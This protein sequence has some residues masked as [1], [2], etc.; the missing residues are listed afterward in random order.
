MRRHPHE[1]QAY[2]KRRSGFGT[3]SDGWLGR[4]LAT[5][6]LLAFVSLAAGCNGE[7]GSATVSFTWEAAPPVGQVFWVSYSVEERERAEVPGN[8]KASAVVGELTV[9][10]WPWMPERPITLAHG[11]NLRLIVELRRG[12]GAEQ[13]VIYYGVSEPFTLDPGEDIRVDVA[14]ELRR[15]TTDPPDESEAPPNDVTLEFENGATRPGLDDAMKASVILVAEVTALRAEIANDP[16]FATSREV[17]LADSCPVTVAGTYRCRVEGWDL[18]AGQTAE[19]GVYSVYARFFDAYGYPSAVRI[20][21]AAID[22]A[23]P[24]VLSA[25]VVPETVAPGGT[26]VVS[27]TTDE[28]IIEP[29]LTAIGTGASWMGEP[30][31]LVKEGKSW[32]WRI[33]VT[34]DAETSTVAQFELEYEDLVGNVAETTELRDLGDTDATS[35]L[36]DG[37]APKLSI[38]DFA[39]VGASARRLGPAGRWHLRGGDEV[40]LSL[41]VRDAHSLRGVADASI[42]PIPFACSFNADR[43]TTDEFGLLHIYDCHLQLSADEDDFK[44]V[45]TIT[46]SEVDDAGNF[47]VLVGPQVDIDREHP[48][49]VAVS[50]EHSDGFAPAVADPDVAYVNESTLLLVTVTLNEPSLSALNDTGLDNVPVLTVDGQAFPATDESSSNRLRFA[51]SASLLSP[52]THTLSLSGLRDRAGNL[53]TRDDMLE[54][55]AAANAARKPMPVVEVDIEDPEPVSVEQLDA[56]TLYRAPYGDDISTEPVFELRG[57]GTETPEQPALWDWC[58]GQSAAFA[59]GT[60]VRITRAAPGSVT[61][62][63][64]FTLQQATVDPLSGILRVPIALDTATVCISQLDRAGNVSAPVAVQYVEWFGQIGTDT[65]QDGAAGTP[66]L[67]HWPRFSVTTQGD[68]A[69]TLTPTAVDPSTC[70]EATTA[71]LAFTPVSSALP[72]REIARTHMPAVS[73][74]LTGEVLVGPGCATNNFPVVTPSCGVEPETTAPVYTESVMAWTG[75]RYQRP[76]PVANFQS[77]GPRIGSAFAFDHRRG[78]ALLFGGDP[79]DPSDTNVWAFDRGLWSID[80]VGVIRPPALRHHRMEYTSRSGGV[81]LFGGCSAPTCN[82]TSDALWFLADGEWTEV[83]ELPGTDWPEPR[84][85]FGMTSSA[86]GLVYVFGGRTSEAYVDI[87]SGAVDDTLWVWDGLEWEAKSKPNTAAPWPPWSGVSRLAYDPTAHELV[88]WLCIDDADLDSCGTAETWRYAITTDAWRRVAHGSTPSGLV[89]AEIVWDRVREQV[90]LVGGA[91]SLCIECAAA[92]V[93]GSNEEPLSPLT[94]VGLASVYALGDGGWA[95]VSSGLSATVAGEI[96][97]ATHAPRQMGVLSFK[98]AAAGGDA[99]YVGLIEGDG[100]SE[101]GTFDGREWHPVAS[102]TQ[103][104]PPLENAT[105]VHVGGDLFLVGSRFGEVRDAAGD[106]AVWMHTPDGW[107]EQLQPDGAPRP[108]ARQAEAVVAVQ[109]GIVVFGGQFDQDS[110]PCPDGPPNDLRNICYNADTWFWDADEAAWTELVLAT[111]PSARGGAAAVYDAVGEKVIL[112]GGFG[113][114]LDCTEPDAVD[115]DQRACRP[116]ATWEFDV[117]AGAWEEFPTGANDVAGVDFPVGR[118]EAAAAF[119]VANNRLVVSGGGRVDPANHAACGIADGLTGC[120]DT[121]VREGT[122]WTRINT[123]NATSSDGPHAARTMRLAY[124]GTGADRELYAVA[125]DDDSDV[126]AVRFFRVDFGADTTPAH[127]L[128]VPQ[129]TVVGAARDILLERALIRWEGGADAAD[130]SDGPMTG[131]RMYA[132]IGGSWEPL[133]TAP[134]DAPA[135]DPALLRFQGTAGVNNIELIQVF[136]APPDGSQYIAVTPQGAHGR[137]TSGA[138][139]TTELVTFRI[140]YSFIE[141]SVP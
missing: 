22:L 38:D 92:T 139:L 40:T 51:V 137:S 61:A 67:E 112:F 53:G 36:I 99:A 130:S 52:G 24:Q 27:V 50:F 85:D 23:A 47:G 17:V 69:A 101:V 63:S 49:V 2:L 64:D 140:R 54:L 13:R 79:V 15:P 60:V 123:L 43:S 71:P 28:E 103:P 86:A 42:G 122:T 75:D 37:V 26:V 39:I 109:G 110:G 127:V 95:R 35:V 80:P 73:N 25:S 131:L 81:W 58:E 96:D 19:A 108:S 14:V 106:L 84:L 138:K 45:T 97:T 124:V 126:M 105:A 100:E 88:L 66:T 18:T 55:G 129:S 44:G 93:P 132:W 76:P 107:E 46:G 41:R 113:N 111:R 65:I 21:Q 59:P 9:G 3:S 74:S 104:L 119:D 114:D 141:P 89:G 1:R 7:S 5:F 135:C 77:P 72:Q 62:C 94:E 20:D 4:C 56:V 90:V 34:N 133:V 136:R 48:D 134:H 11:E 115:V 12:P 6:V 57:C 31:L 102:G 128:R 68:Q 87:D 91:P 98:T 32:V 83:P 118:T 82:T 33:D 30:E 70:G 125:G 116:V 121:W 117:A 120:S 16:S 10:E 29:T 8:V 78:V